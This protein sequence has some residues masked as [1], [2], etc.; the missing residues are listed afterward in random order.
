MTREPETRGMANRLRVPL[1]PD[2]FEAA[3]GKNA[4]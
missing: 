4:T 3:G 1:F 2:L